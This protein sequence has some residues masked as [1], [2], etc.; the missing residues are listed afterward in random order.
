MLRPAHA[1]A[2]RGAKN[3]LATARPF[4]GSR[5]RRRELSLVEELREIRV[6]DG[7]PV[8]ARREPPSVVFP[9]FGAL[10]VDGSDVELPRMLRQRV[11]LVG[12]S[13]RQIGAK[14]LK[15]WSEPFARRVHLSP[16]ANDHTGMVHVSLV[17]NPILRLFKSWLLRDLRK[18]ETDLSLQ[19][20]SCLRIGDVSEIRKTLGVDNRL[21]GYV[22]LLDH[23]GKVHFRG[24][25]LATE[26]EL[27]Q[28]FD[29]A[30][31]LVAEREGLGDA[32]APD[33]DD[34][35]VLIGEDEVDLAAPAP[36]SDRPL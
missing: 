25:G 5:V 23:E 8:M 2:L 13:M 20:R 24:S 16:R 29:V 28:L 26:A 22:F 33:H 17:E 31:E 12:V 7:K 27:E 15:S 30:H 34:D 18:A 14:H 4:T 11:T 6:T 3:A 35:G 9:A 36:T 1:G 21:V 19:R 10:D 32:P